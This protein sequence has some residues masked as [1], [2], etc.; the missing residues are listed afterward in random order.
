MIELPKDAP[1]AEYQRYIHALESLHGWLEVDLVHNCFLMGEEVGE[2][3]KAIRRY[4]RYFDPA[5]GVEAG[6]DEAARK[7]E[8]GE[9]LVDVFN[10]LLALANRL[11]I[12]LEAAFRAKN[13][14][15]QRR[16]WAL[17]RVT[18]LPQR[19][20]RFRRQD[21]RAMLQG[22]RGALPAAD[23]DDDRIH[24]TAAV[25]RGRGSPG[26]RGPRSER[27]PAA[28]TPRRARR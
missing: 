4:K 10:Y 7:A 9:E 24:A 5:D 3:F 28:L 23:L 8:V 11:D 14:K 20:Q 6:E 21:P 1:L 19:V 16:S 12:D 15:N 25:L 2:L 17:A 22:A 13:E 26:R 27:P 18:L